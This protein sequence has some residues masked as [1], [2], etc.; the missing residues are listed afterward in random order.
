MLSF[1]MYERLAAQANDFHAPPEHLP[2]S[3]TEGR[4]T[5]E[6]QGK[7]F[8]NLPPAPEDYVRRP[9]LESDLHK[10]LVDDRHPVVTL[11]GPGGV[12]KTSLALHVMHQ[13]AGTGSFFTMIWC[14]ARD[15]ELLPQ[16]AKVVAPR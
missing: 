5:L 6:I 11:Q 4:P 12:G 3:S 8:G 1:I 15:I 7:C 9:Q 10:V 16:S 2:S 14:S 13:I